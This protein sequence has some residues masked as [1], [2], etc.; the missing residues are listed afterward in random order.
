MEENL[1]EITTERRRQVLEAYRGPLCD[2]CFERDW[3]K[4]CFSCGYIFCG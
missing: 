2:K 4:H 1:L 3:G